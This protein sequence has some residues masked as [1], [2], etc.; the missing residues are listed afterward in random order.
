MVDGAYFLTMEEKNKYVGI[1][2]SHMSY[3]ELV[4][5]FYYG[6]S[7]DGKKRAKDL[8]EKYALFRDFGKNTVFAPEHIT[9]YS[10]GAYSVRNDQ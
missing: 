5:F 6:I 8:V 7:P 4:M 3:Y 1:L 10:D 2:A 9:L